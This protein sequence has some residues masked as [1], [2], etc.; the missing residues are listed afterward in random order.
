M[1][2]ARMVTGPDPWQVLAGL[3]AWQVTEIPRPPGGHAD[4]AAQ[5]VQALASAYGT[6][7][8]VAVAWLRDRSGGSVKVITAGSGLVGGS[9]A[10]QV[11]LTT[12]PGARGVPLPADAIVQSLGEL[13]CW[14]PVAGIADALLAGSARDGQLP[15]S[16]ER[17]LLSAWLDAFGWLVFA[18]PVPSHEINQLAATSAHAQLLAE[19]SSSPR[20]ALAARRAAARHDELRQAV[21]TGLWRVRLLAG[22]TTPQAA[23]RVVRLLC[24]SMDL[25]GL[26]YALAPRSAAV[27][28]PQALTYFTTKPAPARHQQ[29]A[30]VPGPPGGDGTRSWR[31][32]PMNTPLPDKPR[33]PGALPDDPAAAARLA[34]DERDTPAP[35][36]PLV[37]STHLLAA[38]A[39]VPE[40]EVPGLRFTLQPDFDVTP[41]TPAA[42]GQRYIVAGDVLD[43][44]RV[45]CGPLAVPLES[46]NRHVFVCG[47]TGAGKSQTVRNLLEQATAVGIPWLVIEPAKSEYRLMAARLPGTQVITIRPGDLDVPPAG[48]N[49]LEPAALPGGARFPLQTHADLLR[50][51]FLAAFQAD[52]PFPQVLAAALTRCYEQSGWDLV[53]GQPAIPGVQPS[54]PGLQDLQDAAI[55]VVNDIGYGREVRDNVRGFV[56]V[57]IGSL[58]LGTAGRFLDGSHPLD[59]AAL[60]ASNVVLEIEDA[61]DDADKAFLMGAV[62]IRLTEYLRLRHRHEAPAPTLLRHLTVIEEAHRL[63][64]QPTPGAGAGPAAHA[65]EMFADLL[66][67][68]RAYGEGL[69]IAEQIPSKLISDT[70]KNTAVK[71][72]HRLP[73]LDDRQS[74]GATMNLTKSQSAYL[75][76]LPPGEA[77]VFSDGMDYPLLARVPDGT[78]READIAAEPTSPEAVIGRRSMTCGPDCLARAC[79]LL[80]MRAG[81]RVAITDP[82]VTLWAELAVLAHLTGWTMPRPG[83]AFTRGLRAMPVRLRDCALSHAVDRAISSRVQVISSRVS[84]EELAVHVVAAM[85]QAITDGTWLCAKEEPRYLAPQ[86]QWA[87]VR[88]ALNLAYRKSTVSGRH[89]RSDEWEDQY[90]RPIPGDT[91][92]RQLGEVQRW[93]DHDQRDPAATSALVWGTRTFSAIEEA[94]GARASDEDWNQRLTDAL[95][96]FSRLRWPRNYLRPATATPSR[97]AR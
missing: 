84:P 5:R 87:L 20:S 49:P 13:P 30:P 43:Y 86:Y 38:L 59:V 10:G 91:C 85:R 81:K 82:R 54:Y 97:T 47:A 41:E 80:E 12:P 74:V 52:E 23:A 22:A 42:R 75:V 92:A 46:L 25:R 4:G 24:A 28:L 15:P 61:G 35:Q 56:T 33:W 1:R 88:D 63:L 79:T 34:D 67:E 37:A 66:A 64:R 50:A 57:R 19:Q 3:P 36:S 27:P 77:A 45:P 89:P 69:V 31:D 29:S 9:D 55:A 58:R 40:R 11:V 70:I 51:L 6:G 26:P 7:E 60:L 71:I 18:E 32:I 95:S 14:A 39:R 65:T 90:G 16:L 17:G 53:T 96:A 83:A 8:P 76:T 94:I 68:I 78:Q 21:T 73:A 48:L 44:T 72:V 93:Y 2:E 62:L